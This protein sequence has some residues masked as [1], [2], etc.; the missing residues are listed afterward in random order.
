MK[1]DEN[2]DFQEQRYWKISPGRGGEG[3]DECFK[4]GR[5]GIG[6]PEEDLHGLTENEVRTYFKDE[7]HLHGRDINQAIDFIFDIQKND[8]I[9]AYSAPSTIYGIGIVEE[10]DWEFNEAEEYYL[11]TSRKVKWSKNILPT[12]ISDK[13]I[14][15]N[16]GKTQTVVKIDKG[17]FTKR[18]LPLFSKE[19]KIESLIIDNN[20]I[21]NL[22]IINLLNK[23]SQVI[24]YG[25]PGTGKT[26]AAR[27]VAMSLIQNHFKG[28]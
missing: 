21:T 6:W 14:I 1:I 2:P 27:Q 11:S 24:F 5:I 22:P 8:I 16:L 9:I 10:D 7:V 15:E 23:K 26:Y 25:P 28:D 12:K 19:T 17:I 3:W 4:A 13:L 18:I 20:P